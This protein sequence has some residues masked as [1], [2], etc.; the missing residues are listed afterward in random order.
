MAAVW[1]SPESESVCWQKCTSEIWE[2][3][4]FVGYRKGCGCDGRG[5]V[6]KRGD[7]MVNRDLETRF[8]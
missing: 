4:G 6:V 8:G 7:V 5:E 2:Q 3:E 1:L